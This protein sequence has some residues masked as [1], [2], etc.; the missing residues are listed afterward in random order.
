MAEPMT[1]ERRKEIAERAE[2]AMR[3]PWQAV[4]IEVPATD[5]A[6]K[7]GFTK[8]RLRWEIHT[9][10]DH[11]QLHGPDA[12]VSIGGG[13]YGPFVH[14]K[15][16]N[17]EFMAHARQDVPDLLAE[18]ARLRA[19]IEAHAFTDNV[20]PLRCISCEEYDGHSQGCEL[21][22]LLGREPKP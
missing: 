18:N 20:A 19:F 14:L 8:P 21:V 9:T 4:G 11:P 10:W 17:A 22:A 5:A 1:E 6:L 15:R 7:A 16:A 2:K 3:G 13:L 12:V